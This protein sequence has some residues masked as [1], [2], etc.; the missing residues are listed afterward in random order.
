MVKYDNEKMIAQINAN[1]DREKEKLRKE[2]DR[3]VGKLNEEMDK[4]RSA[5][6]K[7]E[8]ELNK[9]ID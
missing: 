4:E 5:K 6:K 9:V 1:F 7:R 3:E 2:H 8:K